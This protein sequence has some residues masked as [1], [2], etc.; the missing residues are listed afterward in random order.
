MMR[1]TTREIS[2]GPSPKM[3]CRVVSLALLLACAHILTRLS[4]K[5]EKEKEGREDITG[6]RRRRRRR[7]RK[8]EEGREK[9][10][11]H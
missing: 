3:S 8:E 4:G 7:R 5:R 11:P 2:T 10:G 1:P 9:I 6:R